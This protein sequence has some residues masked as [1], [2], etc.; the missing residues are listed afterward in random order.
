MDRPVVTKRL[1]VLI[2]FLSV[3]AIGV[4][5]YPHLSSSNTK[6][7]FCDVGQGDAIYLR[8][9]NNIDI[10]VDGGPNTRVLDCLGKYMPFYDRT[11][12]IAIIT[13]PQKDHY[14]GFF[15]ILDRYTVQKLFLSPFPHPTS[16]FQKLLDKIHD[17][18]IS[19]TYINGRN[20]MSFK[21]ASLLFHWPVPNIMPEKAKE[22]ANNYSIVATFEEND[23]R[24]LLTGDATPYVLAVLSQQSNMRS[25][26]L[27]IPH[28]GSKQGLIPEFL[29]LAEPLVSV[30]SVGRNNSYHHPSLSILDMLKASNIKTYRTDVDGDVVVEV[31]GSQ[32]TVH[33][34][35]NPEKL[36]YKF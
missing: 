10:L 25:S 2:L 34:K 7:V 14:F 13:H 35:N 16:L 11:I 20:K 18:N 27:K 36:Y 19:S 9:Q 15:S 28:H 23:F 1:L 21:N 29:K 24:L 4:N 12:E 31:L 33:S 32:F 17:R 3:A 30:I 6:I 5:I 26:L 8:L 22:D